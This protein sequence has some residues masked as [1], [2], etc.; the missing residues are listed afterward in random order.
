MIMHDDYKK[1]WLCI[2][3]IEDLK[4]VMQLKILP[5]TMLSVTMEPAAVKATALDWLI[6]KLFI[7]P[8]SKTIIC[9]KSHVCKRLQNLEIKCFKVHFCEVL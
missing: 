5:K 1:K 3:T 9:T 8:L 4:Q 2:F 7:M 6:I